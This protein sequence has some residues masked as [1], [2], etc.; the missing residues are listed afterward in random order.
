MSI[1][2]K[3]PSKKWGLLPSCLKPAPGTF[4]VPHVF[5]CGMID[6]IDTVAGTGMPGRD[7]FLK[8]P[9]VP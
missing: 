5:F 4:P 2:F 6:G 8:K 3:K 9:E 1:Y 7:A